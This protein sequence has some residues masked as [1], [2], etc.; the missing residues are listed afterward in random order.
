MLLKPGEA[1]PFQ[2][3]PVPNAHSLAVRP[4]GKRLL[5]SATNANSS[6]N[7]RQ[8]GKDKEYPANNSPLH[9]F[10]FAG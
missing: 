4:D 8:L 3:L 2:S 5:V 1:Q 10:E 6:G 7:G 9:G